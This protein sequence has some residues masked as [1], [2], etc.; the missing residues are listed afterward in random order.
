[1]QTDLKPLMDAIGY[2]FHNLKLLE[3][4]LTHSSYS[5]EAMSG[6]SFWGIRCWALSRRGISMRRIGAPRGS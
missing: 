4:A 3:K 6:W 5:N 1:M 2:Q